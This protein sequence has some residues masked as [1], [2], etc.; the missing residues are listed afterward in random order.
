MKLKALFKKRLSRTSKDKNKANKTK[1]G[2]KNTGAC[3]G[4]DDV[5]PAAPPASPSKGAPAKTPPPASPTSVAAAMTTS[6]DKGKP[7]QDF[8]AKVFRKE[9]IDAARK[10]GPVDLDG[11]L[12]DG[13][14]ATNKPEEEYVSDL[15]ESLAV[16]LPETET[17]GGA[18]SPLPSSEQK[19]PGKA[20]KKA[21]KKAKK[22]KKKGMAE[23]NKN[24]QKDDKSAAVDV[25]DNVDGEEKEEEEKK[26]KETEEEEE[27]REEEEE[28]RDYS[29]NVTRLF[30]YLHQRKWTRAVEHIVTEEGRR[31]A[32]IWVVRYQEEE[33]EEKTKEEKTKEEMK[34]LWKLLPIH[35]AIV[36]NAPPEVVQII[37]RKYPDGCRKVDDR[38]CTPLHLAIGKGTASAQV[39]AMLV[40]VCPE[41]VD[42]ADRRGRT[43]LG[44]AEQ[45]S[46][47]SSR[48]ADYLDI[49]HSKDVGI[50]EVLLDRMMADDVS[51]VSADS[52]IQTNGGNRGRNCAGFKTKLCFNDDNADEL[53]MSGWSCNDNSWFAGC[54]ADGYDEGN[55]NGND[56]DS[57]KSGSS[58]KCTKGMTILEEIDEIC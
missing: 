19:K 7:V 23:K 24:E 53:T 2:S 16:A 49:L 29:T 39:I 4:K 15:I 52:I 18:G 27:V 5:A 11:D 14:D 10:A 35:A 48:R 20:E 46:P 25:N 21:S 6:S 54:E 3:N 43:P 17:A 47:E 44:M 42:M 50:E 26:E 41:S 58:N 22:A 8:D 28:I 34:L 30:A 55:S 37:I 12:D 51:M 36:Y 40:R 56:N 1:G 57:S 38:G 32:S 13:D 31:E 9:E 33:K 45:M